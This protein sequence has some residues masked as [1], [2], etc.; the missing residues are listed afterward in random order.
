[1]RTR[2]RRPPPLA[3]LAALAD[4]SPSQVARAFRQWRGTTPGGFARRLRA[5][6][7]QRALRDT[8]ASLP[9]IALAAGYCDQSHVTRELG[10]MLGCTPG[11]LRRDL[12]A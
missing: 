9:E 1:L 6:H 2:F 8:R 11:R 7:A 10:A 12:R 5:E 3:E 4:R